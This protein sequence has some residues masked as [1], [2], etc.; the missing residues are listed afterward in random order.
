[1]RF[2]IDENLPDDAALLLR[3]NGI[4]ADTVRD[5][6][7]GGAADEFVEDVVRNE[8]RV[9]LTLD[10]DF[11]DIRTYPPESYAGIVVLR[12]KRQ[13]KAAVLDLL[14]RLAPALRK[15]SF[16]GQLWIVEPDRIRF[17]RA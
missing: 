17:R 11:G 8:Q 13:D 7:L 16:A 14:K 5:Q 4:E 2:K 1:V 6:G 12:P 9:L 10:R 15:E 3:A